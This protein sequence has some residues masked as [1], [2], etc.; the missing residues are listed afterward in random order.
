MKWFDIETCDK[1]SYYYAV[2]IY[3][4]YVLTHRQTSYMIQLSSQQL[5]QDSATLSHISTHIKAKL[6]AVGN[7]Q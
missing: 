2:P 1:T 7:W 4:T 6:T 3:F 5:Q